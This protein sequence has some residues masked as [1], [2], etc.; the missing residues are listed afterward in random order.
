[1]LEESIGDQT[2]R[3]RDMAALAVGGIE[4]AEAR[5][6]IKLICH[7][8]IGDENVGPDQW[9]VVRKAQINRGSGIREPI[10]FGPVDAHFGIRYKRKPLAGR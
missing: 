2:H 8:V 9:N 3:R 7:V 4:E 10:I 5:G 6:A 1:M